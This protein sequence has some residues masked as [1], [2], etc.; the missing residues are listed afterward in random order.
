M[1]IGK[2]PRVSP[3]LSR[4]EPDVEDATV[5][6]MT[7][8]VLR[9]SRRHPFWY[10]LIGFVLGGGLVGVFVLTTYLRWTLYAVDVDFAT[11]LYQLVGGGLGGGVVG[12]AVAFLYA[13]SL[14]ELVDA[15]QR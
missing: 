1:Y 14:R 11:E 7:R 9:F 6:V 10:G 12:V 5:R 8:G 4:I 2:K 13:A 3:A 15:G